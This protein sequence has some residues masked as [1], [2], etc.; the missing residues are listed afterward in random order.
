MTTGLVEDVRAPTLQVSKPAQTG[1]LWSTRRV[2]SLRSSRSGFD[3]WEEVKGLSF[4]TLAVQ[5][6]ALVEGYAFSATL[7]VP[8][9]TYSTT[10]AKVLCFL[11]GFWSPSSGYIV[12]N[13][14][15]GAGRSGKDANT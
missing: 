14:N 2:V 10:A 12:A 9:S 13:I 11:Q 5:H 15:T 8:N 6:R 1:A 7:G 3:L 4:F